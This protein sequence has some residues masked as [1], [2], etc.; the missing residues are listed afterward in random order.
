MNR[1]ALYLEI[2]NID[3]DLILEAGEARGRQKSGISFVRFAGI[4]ACLCLI[5]AAVLFGISGDTV[6]FNEAEAPIAA[7]VLDPADENTT[8]LTLN[9]QELLGY[10]GLA[11]LPDALCGL[12]R[13][14][15]SQYYVYQDSGNARYDTNVLQYR[16]ADGG[17]TLSVVIAKEDPYYKTQGTG[18]KQSR[19]EGVPV[20]LAA[21][22]NGVYWA[23]M[24]YQGVNLRIVAWGIDEAVFA[25]IVREIIRT[26]K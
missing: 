22:E 5:C 10:Y 23:E 7:K 21:A 19:I 16:S 4:A 1:E 25:N 9:Y 8:I 14:E 6:Y 20:V 2:G 15:Q 26:Q 12:H 24:D 17:Q 18:L 13:L 3:D 11:P